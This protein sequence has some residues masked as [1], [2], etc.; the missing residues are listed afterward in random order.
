[1]VTSSNQAERMRHYEPN[2]ANGPRPCDTHT[3]Q[4]RSADI[5]DNLQLT[6]VNTEVESAL[7]SD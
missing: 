6:N 5:Q 4:K 1:M 3:Y 7:L 2:K